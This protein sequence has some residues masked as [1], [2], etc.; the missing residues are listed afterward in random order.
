MTAWMV[1]ADLIALI[2]VGWFSIYIRSWLGGSFTTPEP[3]YA[4]A[5]LLSFFIFAYSI[6]GLYPGIGLNPIEELQ[7]ITNTTST[8]IIALSV[9]VFLTQ[10]GI[11]FSRLIF[12]FFWIL[13]LLAVPVNRLFARKL[14]FILGLWGEPV[15]LIG[16]GPQG[17]KIYKYL[18]QNPLY[19]FQPVIIVNNLDH[20][21]MDPKEKTGLP[22]ISASILVNDKMFLARSGIRSAILAPTEIP[23]VLRDSLVDEQQCGLQ[24]LILISS[25]NWIGGS[26]VIPHDMGGLLGLEVERN[27]LNVPQRLLKRILDIFLII[28]GCLI[29]F[30][31]LLLCA[32]LIRLDSPGPIFYR[33]ERIGKD[34]QKFHLWKFRTMVPNADEILTKYL[35][36]N[37][38]LCEEWEASHKLKDDPRVTRIG[39]LLRKTSLDELPQLINVLAGEMSLVGPRPIVNDEVKFYEGSFCLYTQVLPGVTGLWQVSGRSDT[40]YAN[41]VSLDEYYI[42]HWS[43][44]MDIYILIRTIWIVIRCSGAY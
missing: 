23:T 8:T 24:R 14:G 16:F 4:I 2:T 27:L 30:P 42:R 1:G 19:G 6:S 43:I 26:A 17:R 5:P 44:Y 35:S 29:G 37:P 10:T 39:K 9:I 34:G 36:E 38:A 18:K 28:F 12:A 25:L 22:V 40:S 32:V 33:Q 31:V 7:R 13:A 11:E 3:Y 15:A 41:R 21:E 20:L